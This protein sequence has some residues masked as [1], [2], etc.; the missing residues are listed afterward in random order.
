MGHVPAVQCADIHELDK[1]DDDAATAE[2][3][4]K[5]DQ[6]VVVDTAFYDDIQFDCET[7][8]LSRSD[9]GHD[10]GPVV[11]PAAHLAE[12]LI[13]EAVDTDVYPVQPCRRKSGDLFFQQHA[14]GS[15]RQIVNAVQQRESLDELAEPRAQ[16]RFPACESDL[17]GPV[18]NEQPGQPFDLVEG[19]PG[20]ARKKLEIF[21]E[22][23]RGHAIRTAKIA[24]VDHRNPQIP[25]RPVQFVDGF[26]DGIAHV[27]RLYLLQRQRGTCPPGCRSL[28]P[29]PRVSATR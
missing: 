19:Q 20:V 22:F 27:I 1:P 29:T 7:C 24:P 5:R 6:R 11:T 14:V 15:E 16:Q 3:A 21:R 12:H 26:V 13:V 8:R 10:P 4:Q 23:L 18:R 17:A 9:P 2:C 28:I 25:D